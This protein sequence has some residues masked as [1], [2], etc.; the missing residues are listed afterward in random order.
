MT[1]KAAAQHYLAEHLH[2]VEGRK[3][4][5]YNP[6]ELPIEELPVIYG[7]NNGGSAG[8]YSACLL[9]EDGESLGGHVCSHEG[10]MENDLGILEGSRLDRHETFRKHY[11][12]GYR[13]IFVSNKDAKTHKGLLLAYEKNQAKAKEAN[14]D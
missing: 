2:Q 11:P 1:T 13:M 10:Y 9:A 8:W 12:N 5:I 4:A 3:W 6:K 7:W 14:N